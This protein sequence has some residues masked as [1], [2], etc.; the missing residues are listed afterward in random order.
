M[1]TT[2]TWR[3][4]LSQTWFFVNNP[5]AK[6]DTNM[7]LTKSEYMMGRSCPIKVQ[8]LRTGFPV[9]A[10]DDP[11]S[12]ELADIGAIIHWM[13]PQMYSTMKYGY[14]LKD[15]KPGMYGMYS[16]VIAETSDRYARMD[17]F[18]YSESMLEVV[19]FKSRRIPIDSETGEQIRCVT[20]QGK[21][22]EKW[23]DLL[24]DV[25]YQFI[26]MLL[27][28]DKQEL[29]VEG[30]DLRAEIVLMNPHYEST[31]NDV[32]HQFDVDPQ[33][34]AVTF[35]G[36]LEQL[37]GAGILIPVDVT[38][39]VREFMIKD[40]LD[41]SRQII[42]DLTNGVGPVL[43]SACATCEFRLSSSQMKG[44]GFEACWG[45]RAYHD[46]FIL[47]LTEVGRLGTISNV[48][49]V[50]HIVAAGGSRI[51]DIPESVLT[52]KFNER[53]RRQIEAAR[54]NAP[55]V[56]DELKSIL[57]KHSY[58]HAFIDVEAVMSGFPFWASSL[59]Y[60]INTFQWS[61]HIATNSTSKLLHHEWLHESNA[62]PCMLF[63][64]SLRNTLANV[65]TIYIYSSYERTAVLAAHT[66]AVRLGKLTKDL[67]DW[68]SWFLDK[69][70]PQIVDML[71]LV[72]NHYMHPE[73]HGSASIKNVV[74]AV[75]NNN[76]NVRA[77]FPEYIKLD[78]GKLVSPYEALP[79]LQGIAG[80]DDIRHGTAAVTAYGALRHNQLL[81]DHERNHIRTALLEYCKLDTAA[82]VMIDREFRGH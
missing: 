57:A 1:L 61:A 23:R 35:H 27:Q 2:C 12:E 47:D 9:K 18:G 15:I 59:P 21:I 45:D 52:P 31:I 69:D 73:M 51:T 76:Q 75:W 7:K 36:D 60:E 28:A 34:Q 49:A 3:V 79:S 72:R 6:G 38:E 33:T 56:S 13:A 20:P 81:P 82:M 67:D 8:H 25:T 30:M 74:R 46:P 78:N 53:Q 48:N 40:V 22:H 4:W 64:Q 16:E 50:E 65:G 80:L 77:M 66:S 19:E 29:V 41:R 58:P 68:V 42:D 71:A 54:T 43:S 17:V 10:D 70:N 26:I 14:E 63:L 24:H 44:S 37:L 32:R 11:F 5:F 62:H 55:I 39:I